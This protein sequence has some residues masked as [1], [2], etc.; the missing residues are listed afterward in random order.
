[1]ISY[2]ENLI[3]MAIVQQYGLNKIILHVLRYI[4]SILN[5]AYV[6]TCIL[7]LETSKGHN[8]PSSFAKVF[9]ISMLSPANK[10]TQNRDKMFQ[11][12]CLRY[13]HYAK[14]FNC[15]KLSTQMQIQCQDPPT[16]YVCVITYQCN[17]MSPRCC[18]GR[19]CCRWQKKV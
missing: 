14:T 5:T 19:C 2:S 4:A 1:M 8:T 18:W 15:N 3:I 7:N 13:L 17:A 11:H 12:L 16:S 6:T 10:F 9:I